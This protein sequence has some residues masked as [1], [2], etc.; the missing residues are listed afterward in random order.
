MTSAKSVANAINRTFSSK[1][2]ILWESVT[3]SQ[4]R[5]YLMKELATFY[6][7]PEANQKKKKAAL[8]LG[9][10]PLSEVYVFNESIQVLIIIYSD[11]L[12]YF[13]PIVYTHAL[14]TINNILA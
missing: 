13:K 3:D 11:I 7:R 9:K 1:G 2:G 10:Q 4:I 8:N 6:G 5:Q 12:L 14:F